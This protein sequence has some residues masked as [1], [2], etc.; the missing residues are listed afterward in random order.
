M[1]SPISSLIL[2]YYLQ[3]IIQQYSQA[4]YFKYVTYASRHSPFHSPY[5]HIPIL[6]EPQ[7]A[8]II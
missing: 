8:S 6:T 2:A 3:I 4:Q 5:H 7:K 1:L